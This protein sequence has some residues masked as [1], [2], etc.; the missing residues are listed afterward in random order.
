MTELT[1]GTA[2][3]FQL[4]AVNAD[5]ESTAAEA[6]PVTPTPGICGRTQQVRDEI[7]NALAGVDDC[8]A[9]TVADLATVTELYINNRQNVTALQSGDFAGLSAVGEIHLRRNA[10]SS[11]PPDLFAGLSALGVLILS[12]NAL[13]SLPPGVFSGLSALE[14]LG[15]N[16]NAGLGPHLT[17]SA[18]SAL[19][20]LRLINLNGIGLDTVPAGVFSGLSALTEIVL[21][22][23]QLTE[24]S[25]GV[26]S[27]LTKLK[28]IRL[29]SNSLRTLPDGVFAGLTDLDLLLLADNSGLLRLTVTLETVAGGQVRAKVLA[30]AP[31]DLALRVSVENGVL[32]RGAEALQVATGSVAGAPVQVIRTEDS[33]EVTVDL[34]TPLPSPA[35]GHSGYEFV[36]AAS[37]LPAEVAD[38]LEREPG[39]EGEFRLAPETVAD[40]ADPDNDR[41]GGKAWRSR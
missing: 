10:L 23:N 11:L 20:S 16:G 5:G 29:A 12:D 15:L 32:A 6:G 9:V 35:P 1:N 18:F 19:A 27:D 40:Y 31:S 14:D 37:G 7:L 30:G 24:L 41:H 8:A 39:V 34:V 13:S 38:A 17:G 4:R 2:Y 21:T 36:R 3:T 22:G 26:F 28:T 25:A 33:G